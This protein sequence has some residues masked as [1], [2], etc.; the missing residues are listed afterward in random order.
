MHPSAV[1]QLAQLAAEAVC[2]QVSVGDGRFH[3]AACL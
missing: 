1:Q 3:V 2:D